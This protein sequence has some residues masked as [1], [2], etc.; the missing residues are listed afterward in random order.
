[1]DGLHLV[2]PSPVSSVGAD[3]QKGRRGPTSER[4]SSIKPYTA[5]RFSWSNSQSQSR[6][7]GFPKKVSRCNTL[8]VDS[9]CQTS[10][11]NSDSCLIIPTGSNASNASDTHNAISKTDKPVKGNPKKKARKKANRNKRPGLTNL[12]CAHGSSTFK[13]SST[14]NTDYVIAPLPYATRLAVLS[15]QTNGNGCDSEGNSSGNISFSESPKICTAYIGEGDELEVKLIGEHRLPTENGVLADFP[16]F[17]ILSG[18]QDRHSNPIGWSNDPCSSR[19]SETN[20]SSV[21]DSTSFCSSDENTKG[22]GGTNL[23]EPPCYVVRNGLFSLPNIFNGVGDSYCH[24]EGTNSCEHGCSSGNL[25]QRVKQ[26]NN[27]PRNPSVSRLSS[28]GKFTGCSG[29]EN[30]HPVW[31]RVQRNDTHECSSGLKK[32]KSDNSQRGAGLK[33]VPLLK[34]K[35]NSGQSSMLSTGEGKN[36]SKVKSP[37]KFRRKTSVESKQ[38]TK[39]S[40]AVC[41]TINIQQNEVDDIS[42]E[43]GRKGLN[44]ITGSCSKISCKRISFL[45]TGRFLEGR[46]SDLQPFERICATISPLND[47]TAEIES[48][49]LS[50]FRDHPDQR[51]LVK[52]QSTGNL[53]P[54]GGGGT[55]VSK[56]ISP[57]E[58]NK[59]ENSCESTL[60]K[61]RPVGIKAYEVSSAD[62]S[63]NLQLAPLSKRAREICR[64]E[65]ATREIASD[66]DKSS[67]TKASLMCSV[68][69][70]RN[71]IGL[72]SEGEVQIEKHPSQRLCTPK[73]SCVN[74][75]AAKCSSPD[76]RDQNYSA[77]ENE[78]NKIKQAISDAYRAQLA[79]EAVQ[80]AT[81]CP[82]AEFERVLSSASPVI[83]L[84]HSILSCQICLPNE[85]AGAPLCRHEMP[86][87]TLGSLW[88]WYER[89]GTYGLE[90][91][92]KECD[93]SKR[94]GI[95]RVAFRAYFV[96]FLSA[97]QL[98]RNSKSTSDS[99][100]R[101]SS[102][103]AMEEA[104][105]F[106]KRPGNS[107][108]VGCLPI[109]SAL[110]P[111]PCTDTGT[112]SLSPMNSKCCTEMSSVAVE[113]NETIKSDDSKSSEVLELL[114]EYFEVEPPQKR[115]PL[116]EMIKELV[117]GDGPSQCRAYG[118]PT[119]LDS[120]AL[121][122]LHHES[123]YSVAWYPIYRIP[124]DNFRAA[125]LTYHSLGHFVRQSVASDS[126]GLG[127]CVVTP[128][129]GL[130]SY[131]AQGEC[132]FQLR[133]PELTQTRE[134]AH[135]NYSGILK[136]RLRT[137][138]QTAS[139][140]ARAVVPKKGNL[141]SVNRQP[142]YEFFLSRRRW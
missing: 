25:A 84:P 105:T 76:P 15:P 34:K 66:H 116:F 1:M 6:N 50:G 100:S 94:L 92:A 8:P 9:S 68:Q 104:C 74:Q 10:S 27:V 17:S 4:G 86:N 85:I 19:Y 5:T 52:G 101:A 23:S 13:T 62:H 129:V 136:E 120:V 64:L 69:G 102:K 18:L 32:V 75:V 97:V 103:E 99:S 87:V 47:Q 113:G 140:M 107:S 12:E 28:S 133:K 83:S 36:Q 7:K 89:H 138:E 72:H 127:A 88:Q 90:V 115:R 55:S 26:I 126:F 21:L 122:D 65:N 45:T 98:F 37:R 142:D 35:S 114:F 77:V 61:W 14:N 96:P 31:Q 49:S 82:I 43:F 134:I 125:F 123:W 135:A 16:E 53:N 58:H 2:S 67:S 39:A 3:Q 137:L 78:S 22:Y 111:Q 81:G 63:K 112:S 124:D 29:K 121:N 73:E 132:W 11:S 46:P 48:H 93:S 71:H 40:S 57:L 128:V 79:S 51:D 106:D 131:N 91:R 41:S 118:D 95:D 117:R 130:Q 119:K 33:D 60:R 42:G 24:I 20:D 54:C 141:T 139:L 56:D 70:A 30:N 38:S 80:M 44:S 110:F 59:Q 108:N 109:F